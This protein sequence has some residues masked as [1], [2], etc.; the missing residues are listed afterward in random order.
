MCIIVMK[1]TYCD[2]YKKSVIAVEVCIYVDFLQYVAK[3]TLHILR[4]EA[5]ALFRHEHLIKFR[6]IRPLCSY[7]QTSHKC[8]RL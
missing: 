6:S 3:G 2:Q 4:I 8:M 1:I 7:S 5:V